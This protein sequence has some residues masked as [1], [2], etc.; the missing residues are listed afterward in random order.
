MFK[1]ILIFFLIFSVIVSIASAATFTNY[2]YD[3]TETS[4]HFYFDESM[5]LHD[6]YYNN[7]LVLYTI[8]KEGF[9]PNLNPDTDYSFV[10]Y[11]P[12]SKDIQIVTGH[13]LPL[14]INDDEFYLQYGLIGLLLL[15]ISCLFI[16]TRINYIALISILL[17]ICRYGVLHNMRIWIY[18]DDSIC[19][20][21][22]HLD[23]SIC[24]GR[25][26]QGVFKK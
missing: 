22:S 12:A 4:L 3:A 14:I 5:K 13:T 23:S 17:S 11:E 19:G 6:F 18:Y 8:D 1:K 24:Q 21:V 10:I 26:I 15:I 2:T 20:P 25:I 16:S 9:I 7:E